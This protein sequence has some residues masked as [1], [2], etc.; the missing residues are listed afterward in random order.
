VP[1]GASTST[2]YCFTPQITFPLNTLLDSRVEE[3]NEFM[4]SRD[5]NSFEQVENKQI[6][7][8]GDDYIRTRINRAFENAIVSFIPRSRNGF[9]RRHKVRNFPDWINSLG[10]SFSQRKCCKAGDGA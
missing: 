2:G 4:I 5:W 10:K 1:I 6:F 8:I 9:L 3:I 7:I